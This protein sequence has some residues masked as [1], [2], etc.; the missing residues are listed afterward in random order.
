MK[1]LNDADEEDVVAMTED[2][3]IGM[4]I[5]HRKDFIKAWK[6]RMNDTH[7]HQVSKYIHIH[8]YALLNTRE[9]HTHP[10]GLR[11]PAEARGS[12]GGGGEGG[13]GGG[14]G[15][16]RHPEHGVSPSTRFAPR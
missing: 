2:S 6:A 13:G 12:G 7:T 14:G 4:K 11:L 16:L 1:R 3:T 10:T 15:A 9:R 8:T 5:P